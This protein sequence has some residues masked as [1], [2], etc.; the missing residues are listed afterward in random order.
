MR[1]E[2]VAVWTGVINRQ[3]NSRIISTALRDWSGKLAPLSKPIRFKTNIV[4]W[5]LAFSH[6]S[7]ER[8]L[9]KRHHGKKMGKKDNCSRATTD[10]IQN[11][12]KTFRLNA[13]V[14]IQES[15]NWSFRRVRLRS[16]HGERFLLAQISSS[17]PLL[18]SPFHSCQICYELA[19]DL[20]QHPFNK[21]FIAKSEL[22]MLLLSPDNDVAFSSK[23]K[24]S[25]I[26]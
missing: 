25:L 21:S 19:I 6:A 20:V 24:R 22:S 11:I 23:D 16:V 18:S 13:A 8:S 15:D 3:Q 26:Y 17:N 1:R 14:W 9:M 7:P 4:N 10:F 5:S 12:I 2:V